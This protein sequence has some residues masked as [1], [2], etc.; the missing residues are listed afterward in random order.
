[1]G[2]AIEVTIADGTLRGKQGKD[3]HDGLFYSFLGIPYAKP[4]IGERRFKAPEPVEPWKGVKDA[5]K[6]GAECPQFMA[7]TFGNEDNCLNLNVFTKELGQGLKKPVMVFVH[8]GGFVSGSN[9][10]DMLYGPQ[11]LMTEDIVLVTIN[12]RLG[13][14]GFLSLKDR[15]LNVPGNA[16]MKDQVM[17]LRWVQRNIQYFGGDPDNVTIFGE[18]AGS[19]SVHFLVVSPLTK[20]LFHKAICQSGCVLNPWAT[21]KPNA[22]EVAKAM[23]YRSDAD[24][25]Y[26]LKKMKNASVGTIMRG[27]NKFQFNFNPNYIRPTSIVVE[28]PNEGAFLTQHPLD[29]LK[30]GAQNQVPMIM[31]YNSLE[32]L[33]FEMLGRMSKFEYNRLPMSLES[34]VPNNCDVDASDTKLVAKVASDIKK[35]YYKDEKISKA[36]KPIRYLIN[37]DTVFMYGIQKSIQLHKKTSSKPIYAYRMSI[38]SNLNVCKMFAQTKSPRMFSFLMGLSMITGT[39]YISYSVSIM[40]LKKANRH[41]TL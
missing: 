37:N 4:P 28:Y 13:L 17:A 33:F 3:Y 7:V 10:P 14:L 16:G 31:G 8:G 1:M 29:I 20:G 39:F 40:F 32:G 41:I 22:A 30:A 21:G 26:I 11:F 12:Y 25:S 35:F 9:R 36:N 19:A 27:Q 34:D 15:S 5:T 38:E 2:K 6:R 24:E 18:S 23:G